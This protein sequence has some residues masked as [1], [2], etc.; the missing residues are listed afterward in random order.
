MTIDEAIKELTEE[1]N[2]MTATHNEEFQQAIRLAIHALNRH[3]NR[4]TLTFTG[5]MGTLP[6]EET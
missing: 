6:G 1:F 5:L 4:H 3:Q 2:L